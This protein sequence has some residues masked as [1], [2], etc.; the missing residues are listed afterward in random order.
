MT[1]ELDINTEPQINNEKEIPTFICKYCEQTYKH[2][3]SLSKHIKYSCTKNK[4]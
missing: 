2:K 1:I 4:D 3:S